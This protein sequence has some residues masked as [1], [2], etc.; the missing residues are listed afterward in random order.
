MGPIER[1]GNFVHRAIASYRDNRIE[2]MRGGFRG[3]LSCVPFAPCIGNEEGIRFGNQCLRNEMRQRAF[4]SGSA[5]RI[6]DDQVLARHSDRFYALWLR[7]RSRARASYS[8]PG[9]P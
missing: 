8:L 1:G 5:D 6:D 7:I 3:K 4:A 2:P 9:M